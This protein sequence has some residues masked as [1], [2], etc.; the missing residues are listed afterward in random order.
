MKYICLCSSSIK[1][2]FPGFYDISVQNKR[3]KET[4][5]LLNLMQWLQPH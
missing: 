2:F 5:M 1:A 3:G 4:G